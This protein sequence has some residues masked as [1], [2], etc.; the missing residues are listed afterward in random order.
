MPHSFSRKYAIAGMGVLAG[1]FPGK[2]ARSLEV[3]PVRLAIEDAG[4]RREDIDGAIN[5]RIESGSGESEGWTDSFAR[6][7]GLP[8][9]FYFTVQRGGAMT[10]LAVVAAA[11]M[12]ELGIAKYVVVGI[13]HQRL[14]GHS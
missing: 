11:Q 14:V 10:H 7:L 12:L 6:I 8:V 2:S 9:K 5:T 13:R 1:R 4:L 3:E